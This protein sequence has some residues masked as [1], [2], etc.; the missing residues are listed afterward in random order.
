MFNMAVYT[1]KGQLFSTGIDEHMLVGVLS[2]RISLPV[3]FNT[4]SGIAIAKP[5][6]RESIGI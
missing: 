3:F 4:I 2:S 6:Y 1:R 5:I